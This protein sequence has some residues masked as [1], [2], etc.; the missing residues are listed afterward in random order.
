MQFLAEQHLAAAKRVRKNGEGLALS[1]NYLSG[2]RIAVSSARDSWRKTGAASVWTISTGG[3][4]PPIGVSSMSK[5]FGLGRRILTVHLSLRIS[6]KAPADLVAHRG[7]RQEGHARGRPRRSRSPVNP[8][9]GVRRTGTALPR[10]RTMPL[11]R[12][13]LVAGQMPSLR[14]PRH[15]SP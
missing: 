6:D 9:A 3:R 12:L 8:N 1:A 5:F 2:S 7:S 15:H 10:D 11:W 13:R 14:D 4:S